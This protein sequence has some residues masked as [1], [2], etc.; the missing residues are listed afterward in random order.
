MSIPIGFEKLVGQ[1][2][3][4]KKLW[5]SPTEPM[6]ESDTTARVATTAKG[7]FLILHYNWDFEGSLQ[8]GLL[9]VGYEEKPKNVEIIWVDSWH[10]Q[11]GIMTCKGSL[12]EVNT[13]AAKGSYLVPN[14]PDWGWSIRLKLIDENQWQLQMD[15][16]TPEGEAMLAVEIN[17]FREA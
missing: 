4:V 11:D 12:A 1:W 13:V 5:I 2:K 17:Y 7:K 6:R 3:G 8:D 15:N 14:S 10:M 16:I 9:L